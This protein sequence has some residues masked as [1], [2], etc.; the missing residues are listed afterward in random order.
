MTPSQQ[1]ARRDACAFPKDPHQHAV[2]IAAAAAHQWH[3]AQGAGE[4]TIPL[5]V[6][7]ALSFLS[8]ADDE[9]DWTA[10]T[11]RAATIDQFAQ[12][13]RAQWAIFVTCRPDLVNRAWPLISVWHGEHTLSE[14]KLVA[15]K[16]IS[17]AAISAGLLS[18][19]GTERRRE[20]DLFGPLLMVLRPDSARAARGQIY[21]P[22]DLSDAIALLMPPEEGDSVLE[23]AVGT[24]GML[25]SAAQ[26]V[27]RR[28]GDPAK[29]RWC[30]VD[31]DELAVACLSVNVVLWE[32]G[33]DV[34]LG[35][36]DS[37]ADDGLETPGGTLGER[38]A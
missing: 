3:H 28:G 22:G 34:V 16:Q 5:S 32:L 36:G 35:V 12:I 21:T 18:L 25:R 13:I 27:R 24:G 17:D 6:I 19:T 29:V 23:P 2:A 1:P 31:I 10:A 9:R 11:L 7:A 20:T 14:A 38:L 37:L 4:I 33:H 15:A 8:P 26:A 30:A